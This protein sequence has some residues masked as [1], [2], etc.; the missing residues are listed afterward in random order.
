MW[1]SS[2]LKGSWFQFLS[3]LNPLEHPP[4]DRGCFDLHNCSLPLQPQGPD[5]EVLTLPTQLTIAVTEGRRD[6][7]LL[8][9]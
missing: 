4:A 3:P 7:Q 8:M 5:R 1:D 6:R 2:A 9:L